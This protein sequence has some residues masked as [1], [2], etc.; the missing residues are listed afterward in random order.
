MASGEIQ[1]RDQKVGV[2]FCT[3]NLVE[4]LDSEESV[5]IVEMERHESHELLPLESNDAIK[6][7]SMYKNGGLCHDDDKPVEENSG[8]HVRKHPLIDE[9]NDDYT[10]GILGYGNYGRAFAKRLT[11]VGMPFY[12]GS[13]DP[14]RYHKE[15]NTNISSYSNVVAKADVVIFAMPARAYEEVT[16][17]LKRLLA[18]KIVVDISNAERQSDR[19]HAL[20]LASLL[21]YSYVIKAF[22]T[23]SAWSMENDIYGASRNVFVC[24]DHAASRKVVVQLVQDLGFSAIDRGRLRAARLLEKLPLQLFPTWRTA[25]M[26]AV[27]LLFLQLSYYYTR[28]LL[29]EEPKKVARNL[30][31]YHANRILCWMALW[32]LSLVYLPGNF[33]GFIQLYRG[34]KYSRFPVW[35]DS[36]MKSRK[37]LGL[38]AMTFAGMH[39]CMSCIALAGEY[40]KYM[41]NVV[42]IPGTKN[43]VYFHFTWNAEISLLFAVLAMTLLV[44]LG[45]TS[46]PTVNQ[47]MSWKEWDFIQSRLGHLTLLFAFSHVTIYAF[48]VYDPAYMKYW[49]YNLPPAVYF[50][51]MLPGL[52]L[53]LKLILLLPGIAGRLQKIRQGWE[54]G[55]VSHKANNV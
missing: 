16:P 17:E 41:S 18:N 4:K 35:F 53:L 32:L 36:W 51:P 6:A 11:A 7:G 48:K 45:I 22:N 37:Q 3:E 15:E 10:I 25:T 2:S 42:M 27:A 31:L 9:N 34:T 52:V 14:W 5:D 8:V 38:Y 33:A 29:S 46:L 43:F 30:S 21:P 23:V 28:E 20:H 1:E 26:I 47:A 39:A 50:Q 24:G 55:K 54:R 49:K 12:I 19:C 44:L 40:V 13:R